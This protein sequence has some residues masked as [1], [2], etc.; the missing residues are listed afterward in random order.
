MN[1]YDD[2]LNVIDSFQ[3]APNGKIYFN[4]YTFGALNA[5]RTIH[6]IKKWANWTY[7]AGKADPPP[8]FFC[9]KYNLMMEVMRVDDHAHLD[10]RGKWVNPVNQRESM[11]QNDI[12]RKILSGNPNADF[13]KIKIIINANPKLP[14]LEDHNYGFY[15]TNFERILTKHIANIPLYRRNHPDKKLIFFIFDESTGYLQVQDEVL[16]KRGPVA[17]EPFTAVPIWHFY[18][19]RFLDVFLE[20]DVD[21]LIWYTPY[22]MFH[23]SKIQPPNICIFDIKKHKCKKAI[24]YTPELAISSEA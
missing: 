12:R 3:G 21:Y 10:K 24:D 6:S 15:Y 22:K 18:D 17:L 8:D 16:A 13:S 7:S 4:R 14:S 1:F 9:N 2:E 19:K 5:F 23:G 20:S 11:I